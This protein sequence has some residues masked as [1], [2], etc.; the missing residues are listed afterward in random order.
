MGVDAPPVAAHDFLGESERRYVVGPARNEARPFQAQAPEMLEI[1]QLRLVVAV[2]EEGD[3]L[4]CDL[5]V[6]TDA[7]ADVVPRRAAAVDPT[8]G[9]AVAR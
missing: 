8:A 3:R 9:G 1:P 7:E 5:L 6:E 2:P 4:V